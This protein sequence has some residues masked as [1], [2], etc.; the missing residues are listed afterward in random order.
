[1]QMMHEYILDW[2][3]RMDV[4]DSCP[5]IDYLAVRW[6]TLTETVQDRVLGEVGGGWGGWG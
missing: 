6:Q 1:M 3:S 5:R 4:G 2:S